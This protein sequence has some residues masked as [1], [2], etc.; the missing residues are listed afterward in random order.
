M[1]DLK[2]LAALTI[3]AVAI[4]GFNIKGIY[5]FL[6]PVYA[7][8]LIPVLELIFP[9][10]TTNVTEEV[11]KNKL[12]NKLFDWLLYFNLPIVFGL[13][14]FALITL[15]SKALDTYEFIGFVISLGI[16]LGVNGI[17]VGH[18][19]GHRQ[20]TKERYLGKALLL[21][22]LYMHF[23]IEHNFGHHLHAA[24]KEDP[25]TARYNQ[26]VYSFWVTSMFRQY[27]SAW[28]IQKKLLNNQHLTLFSLKNDMFWFTGIQ[29]LY[30]FFIYLFFGNLGLVFIWLSAITGCLLLE[31]VNYIEHY[32]LLRLKT[33]SG[34]Y[35]RVKA[36]HSWNSNHVIGRIVLYELTRHSDHHYKTSKKYQILDCHAESPQLPFGYPTSMVLA[37]IPPIWFHIM[38]KRVPREMIGA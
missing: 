17:N 16:V 23:Y 1:K 38:N 13:V 20:T 34:R 6:T 28:D 8:I 29:A 27:I 36:I 15:K 7:F 2:Y 14:L 21:P 3:P 22:A 11:S 25:A 9:V 33:A 4:I 18:E 10:Y 35:E 30:L 24:T 12:K 5:A 26:T 37:M 32:G 19:L 31:T